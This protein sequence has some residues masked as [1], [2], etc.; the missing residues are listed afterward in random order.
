MEQSV[1]LLKK[2]GLKATPQRIAIYDYLLHT[3]AH[4]TVDTI[5]ASLHPTHPTMSL[6][7]VYRNLAQFKKDGIIVSV[8]TVNGQEHFDGDITPHHHF[9]CKKCG[10]ILDIPGPSTAAIDALFTLKH[11]ALTVERCE[12]TYYG[13]CRQCKPE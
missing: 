12:V 11:T 13:L 7:T 5:Y 1:T 9:I 3:E 2:H 8:G 6:A 10:C 4:P